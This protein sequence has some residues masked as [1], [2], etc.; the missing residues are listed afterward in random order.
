MYYLT[1]S[2]ISAVGRW[3]H[4]AKKPV[5]YAQLI[6]NMVNGHHGPDVQKHVTGVRKK[7]SREIIVQAKN[8]GKAC[9][10]KSKDTQICNNVFCPDMIEK[11]ADFIKTDEEINRLKEEIK[12]CKES[13][14]QQLDAMARTLA[15][16][17][18][19]TALIENK[20][21]FAAEK[22]S[23]YYL[24]TGDITGYD[25]LID[26]GNNFNPSTG[27]FTVGNKEEDEG[28]YVFLFSGRKDASG[29]EGY[30]KVYKNG[31]QVQYNYESDASHV[32]QMNDIMSFNLEKGDRI[33]LHNSWS[34][35]IYVQS[36]YHPFTFTG[37][38]I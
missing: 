36:D 17:S 21:R 12:E 24:P 23:G 32:L 2:K 34:D 9:G 19:R 11:L 29:K 30:I 27:V 35:S 31:I 5:I 14:S 33:K 8:G 13:Q 18:S 26:V 6:A 37:Y 10:K 3:N 25:E 28:T 1:V 16:L 15:T 22:R 7:R 20:P 4:I 38:K